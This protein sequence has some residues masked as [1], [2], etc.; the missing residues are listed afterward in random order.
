MLT[1]KPIPVH[2]R[3]V[4][5]WGFGI[6]LKETSEFLQRCCSTFSKQNSFHVLACT[7]SQTENPLILR[8]VLNRLRYPPSYSVMLIHWLIENKIKPQMITDHNPN[9][10]DWWCLRM[11]LL[12]WWRSPLRPQTWIWATVI[13][14]T[15]RCDAIIIGQHM[16]FPA[17]LALK[18]QQGCMFH[19]GGCN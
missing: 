11:L 6:L 19:P 1:P 3:P 12:R 14:W 2:H 16:M 13:F 15:V 10:V 8:I 4:S 7:G 5:N 17:R 9:S 18:P